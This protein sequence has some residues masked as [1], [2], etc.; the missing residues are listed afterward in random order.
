V[1]TDDNGSFVLKLVDGRIR[2]VPVKV[3]IVNINR[4]EITQGLNANDLVVLNAVDDRE[5]RD[6]TPARPAR[7]PSASLGLLNTVRKL[8]VRGRAG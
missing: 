2:S 5:L 3:G 4:V 8:L 1:R 7:T 6:G